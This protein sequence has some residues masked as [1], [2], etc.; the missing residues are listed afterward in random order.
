MAKFDLTTGNRLASAANDVD[1]LARSE[2]ESGERKTVQH[3]TDAVKVMEAINADDPTRA[4]S[5]LERRARTLEILTERMTDA[6]LPHRNGPIAVRNMAK[7][8][9]REIGKLRDA[10][11]DVTGIVGAMRGISRAIAQ[12]AKDFMV[13]LRAE[14]RLEDR[15]ARGLSGFGW[16]E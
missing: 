15:S 10:E 3:L 11:G 1:I 2:L 12:E 9:Q 4:P 6:H 14:E 13:L 5:N 7:K 16:S 8:I